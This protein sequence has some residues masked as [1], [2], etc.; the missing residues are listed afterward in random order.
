MYYIC[1]LHPSTDGYLGRAF[2]LAIVT[3]APVHMGLQ[4]DLQHTDFISFEH[5]SSSWDCWIKFLFK[6]MGRLVLKPS[7]L[8]LKPDLYL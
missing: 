5:R 6:Y 8:K 1:F 4:I 2:L 3:N 7:R